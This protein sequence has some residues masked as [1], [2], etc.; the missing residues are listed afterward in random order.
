MLFRST[1][2]TVVM[3]GPDGECSRITFQ[4][5]V[6]RIVCS[7][8]GPRAAVMMIDGTI[9]VVALG[10]GTRLLRIQSPPIQGELP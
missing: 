10:D 5:E 6:V 7:A 8:S 4:S 1:E 2:N 3:R 9:E